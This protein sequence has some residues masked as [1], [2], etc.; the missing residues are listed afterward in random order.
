MV[1]N[2]QVKPT[3]L[4]VRDLAARWSC[5]APHIYRL[6]DKGQ[7]P[8]VKIGGGF[9]FNVKTIEAIEQGQKVGTCEDNQGSG[10]EESEET[11][12]SGS[13]QTEWSRQEHQ[14][15]QRLLNS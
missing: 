5:S 15:T 6:K 4:K 7:I 2:R 11:G 1:S 3:L 8:Y 9:Y 12:I 14:I 10:E 13:D